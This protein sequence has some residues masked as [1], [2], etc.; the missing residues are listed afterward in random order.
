MTRSPE[1]GHH[2]WFRVATDTLALAVDGTLK[3]TYPQGKNRTKKQKEKKERNEVTKSEQ[4]EHRKHLCL[5]LHSCL[6]EKCLL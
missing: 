6:G 5:L 2:A 3:E 1:L 4:T